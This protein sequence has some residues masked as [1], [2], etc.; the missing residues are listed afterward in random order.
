MNVLD[1]IILILFI[2]AIIRGISKGLIEQVT[3][4]AS[5]VASAYLANL[6][7]DK[8]GAFLSQWIDVGPQLLYIISF[9]IVVVLVVLLL[10]LV[11]KLATKFIN[12]IAMGWIN[13]VL[14]FLFALFNAA[15]VMGIVLRFLPG[16]WTN[17]SVIYDAII[18]PV[19]DFIFP[20]LEDIFSNISSGDGTAKMC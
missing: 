20:F 7:S 9:I 10:Q 14:G 1:I 5:L 2:P 19:T 8:V 17:G 13:R 18:K 11:S 16:E 12:L 15:V 6:F 3:A 4:F